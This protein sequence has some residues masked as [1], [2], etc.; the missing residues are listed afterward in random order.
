[1]KYARYKN[2]DMSFS[3]SSYERGTSQTKSK[4]QLLRMLPFSLEG[5]D[6]RSQVRAQAEKR[7][8]ARTPT[9]YAKQGVRSTGLSCGST[10]HAGSELEVKGVEGIKPSTG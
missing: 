3:A 5:V 10:G 1:M 4:Q 8:A 2:T 6:V 9:P 7:R